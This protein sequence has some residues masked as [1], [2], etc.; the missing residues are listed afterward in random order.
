M[1]IEVFTVHCRI[2]F[3]FVNVQFV[4]VCK[5]IPGILVQ[6]IRV[7]ASA[8][9]APALIVIAVL[10][11]HVQP[12]A[13]QVVVDPVAGILLYVRV[14]DGDQ[15]ASVRGEILRHRDAVGE[16]T[17]VPSEVLLPVRVL[18]VQPHH[19]HGDIVL[20]KFPLNCVHIL[21]VIVIPPKQDLSLQ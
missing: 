19:V 1:T 17:A 2:G 11:L 18:Y 14:H 6:K 16:L 4:L 21:L 9:P 5:I 10:V 8:R 12:L 7:V 20:V 13:G 3:T 15:L